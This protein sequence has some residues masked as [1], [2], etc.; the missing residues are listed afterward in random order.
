V[1]TG[2]AERAGF[3]C[4]L[5]GKATHAPALNSVKASVNDGIAAHITAASPGGP[6]YDASLTPEH[7]TGIENAIY[8]C[9]GCSRLIDAN[10]GLD[11]TP[12][13]LREAKAERERLA[14]EEQAGMKPAPL[15]EID[16]THSADGVGEVTGLRVIR[17]AIIKPGTISHAS[18]IGKITGTKIGGSEDEK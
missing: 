6:R 1:I 8:V 17:P 9:A 10:N 15:T 4:T 11:Y 14:R 2:V 18:G 7:R 16:G 3:K 13:R 5:C 12:T